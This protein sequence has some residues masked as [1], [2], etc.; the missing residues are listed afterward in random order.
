MICPFYII[1]PDLRKGVRVNKQQG[2]VRSS[3]GFDMCLARVLTPSETKSTSLNWECTSNLVRLLKGASTNEII[4]RASF[5]LLPAKL[6]SG[7]FCVFFSLTCPE[8][9]YDKC[10]SQS[11]FVIHAPTTWLATSFYQKP[12]FPRL[13]LHSQKN[14]I[15]KRTRTK[16]ACL[17]IFLHGSVCW[18]SGCY[19]GLNNFWLGFW[20]I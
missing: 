14:H 16:Y 5:G 6:V 3:P 2:F 18:C 13:M 17:D 12:L 10:R 19:R 7:Y 15:G 1:L 11:L 20:S 8:I 9:Q 4:I